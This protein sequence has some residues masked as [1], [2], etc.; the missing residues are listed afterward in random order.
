MTMT[1]TAVLEITPSEEAAEYGAWNGRVTSEPV[2]ML[3]V[4]PDLDTPHKSLLAGCPKQAIRLM[5]ADPTWVSRTNDN[6]ET[7]L[8]VA[9]RYGPLEVVQWLLSNGADANARA[10]NQFA[11]LHLAKDA[12]VAGLLLKHGAEADADGVG[13]TPLHN[14]RDPQVVKVLLE[15]G[16]RGGTDEQHNETPLELAARNYAAFE[17]SSANREDREREWAITRLLLNAGVN[18][19]I[20]AACYLDD[21]DRVRAILK[22]DKTQALDRYAMRAAAEYGHAAIVKLLLENGADPED[23]DYDSLTVS[24]FAIER[25]KVLGL[26]FD[27]GADP[28]VPVDYQGN[29]W[30]PTG[31]TLLH[32]AAGKG[33]VESAGVLL[34]YGVDVDMTT[35]DGLTPLHHACEAGQ[36]AMVEFLL[37]NKADPRAGA[38]DGWTPMAVAA[39]AIRPESEDCWFEEHGFSTETE[40]NTGRVVAIRALQRAGVDIDLPAAIACDD[41]EQVA[42]ILKSD[43]K[44]MTTLTP[45]GESP[46]SR[47]VKLNHA[48]IVRLLLDQ[49]CSP[50]I[51]NQ[52]VEKKREGTTPLIE[53]AFWGHRKS[54]EC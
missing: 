12:Q 24:Y 31:L 25:S 26:L 40:Q 50:E 16:A 3:F 49:G 38:E 19:N 13:G 5:Q 18:Y 46:L 17:Q 23:A 48:N 51:R 14:A 28:K 20:R 27:A 2:K 6:Q 1:L 47:A 30:G 44:A 54:P 7:P 22:E 37:R 4:A 42:K 10:Y 41:I 34:A 52:D 36:A 35:P 21:M 53:A 11:P 43:P 29:G 8:H 45:D 33:A 32:V 9:A 39:S 15:R